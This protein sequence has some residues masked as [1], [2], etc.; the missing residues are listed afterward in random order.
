MMVQE[1]NIYT[2]AAWRGS[3]IASTFAAWVKSK[4]GLGIFIHWTKDDTKK[5]VLI[6]HYKVTYVANSAIQTIIGAGSSNS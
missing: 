3:P 6:S 2:Y 5:E 1:P 4:A